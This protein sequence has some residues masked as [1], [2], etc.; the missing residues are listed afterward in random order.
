MGG[1]VRLSLFVSDVGAVYGELEGVAAEQIA[2][3]T[4]LQDV[5][6]AAHAGEGRIRPGSAGLVAHL[7][8]RLFQADKEPQ[9]G[10]VTGHDAAQVA[11]LA[12]AGLAA[13]DLHDIAGIAGGQNNALQQRQGL[14]CRVAETF[15]RLRIDGKKVSHGV[16]ISQL[17]AGS[18][19]NEP[20]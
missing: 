18:R 14:L 10:L 2:D 11:N 20:V 19:Q 5:Y 15:C 12:D 4:N 1:G 8:C 13:L 16:L 17:G 7:F 6:F 9:L 3:G